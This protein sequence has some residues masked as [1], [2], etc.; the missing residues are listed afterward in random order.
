[1]N[2]GLAGTLMTNLRRL[3]AVHRVLDEPRIARFVVLLGAPTVKKYV[4][5]A[6]DAGRGAAATPDAAAIVDAVLAR[7]A[8]ERRRGLVGVLNGTGILLHTN[9]GRAPL[10][11]EALDAIAEAAGGASNLEYDLEAGARGSRYDRVGALLRTATGAEDALV[12][13]N[14]AAAVLLVLDTFA[15]AP[16]GAPREVIVA[17][18]QLVEIGGG[19]RLPDVL[20]RSGATLVEVGAT[21]KVRPDDYARAL[22]ARTALLLRAHPSNYRIEGFV[23]EVAG[24]ELVALGRRAGV[25]VVE[26][27][28]SGAL[29]DLGAYGLPHERTVQEALAEEIDL[30]A[31]SGDKLLGGPQAGIVVGRGALIARMRANPLLR[32]LRVGAPTLAALAATLRLHLDP[33]A[34]ERIPFYR[35]LATAQATLRARGEGLR[36][37]LDGLDLA[38]IETEGYA[39]GG[40]LPLAPLPSIALA[41]RPAQV[42]ANAAAARLRHGTPPLIARAEDDRVVIDLRT[43]PPE[44]DAEVATALEAAR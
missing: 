8:A 38:V 16:D 22:T 42:P 5:E 26:D 7:C 31:F 35:M 9:L 6:L 4:A 23:A 33:A 18:N 11:R 14:G 44:R 25:P 27:L 10:A 43:I 17:R 12:V 34:R 13:N 30:V 36:A 19:F 41:W 2:S 3:P 15:R 24:S 20:A 1:V 37:R 21:N 28:G 40:S 32:A 39:G 29:V